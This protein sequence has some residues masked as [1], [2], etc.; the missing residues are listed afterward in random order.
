M[1]L[2]FIDY[3]KAFYTVAHDILWND[4]HKMGFPT[5]IILLIKTL[6]DQQ[7]AAVG[8]SYILEQYSLA[9]AMTQL[10]KKGEFA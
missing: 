9:T 7:K 1:F 2:C 4:M 5:R 8:T 10:K 6:Y 3:S